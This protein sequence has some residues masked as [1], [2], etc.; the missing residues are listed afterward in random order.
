M[1]EKGAGE[2]RI[3]ILVDDQIPTEV[4]TSPD[5]MELDR[6]YA[7]AFKHLDS[8]GLLI[9][10]ICK[11]KILDQVADF[12]DRVQRNAAPRNPTFKMILKNR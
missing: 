6:A 1:I 11:P 8:Y 3:D 9:E 2:S 7:Q 5:T 10:L 4:K 12:A